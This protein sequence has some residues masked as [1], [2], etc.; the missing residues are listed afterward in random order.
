MEGSGLHGV[1]EAAKPSRQQGKPRAIASPSVP[2]AVLAFDEPVAQR[3]R[4]GDDAPPRFGYLALKRLSD[5]AGAALIAVIFSP[6]ILIAVVALSRSGGAIFGQERVGKGGRP[7]VLYKFRS[8]VPDADRALA[9]LLSSDPE[10]CAEWQRDHKLRNDPRVT[11][12]GAILRRSSLDEL[13]Q[14][15]NVIR[16]DMSLVGP[17][18]VIEAELSKYG[19]AARYYLGLKPGLTGLWQVTGRN[20]VNYRRRVALDRRY[21]RTASLTLDAK[22]LFKTVL[23]VLSAKG[24]Y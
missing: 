1:A 15:W 20:D 4:H 24:A 22:V 17:R 10:A 14:L 19:R 18:P 6:L 7:F 16:G 2:I 11:R 13:P 12:L 3:Q 9:K 23:V 8:M 21:A 5:I